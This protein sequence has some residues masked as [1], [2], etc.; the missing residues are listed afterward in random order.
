L[1]LR[2]GGGALTVHM[3]IA[4]TAGVG[5]T[6]LLGTALMLLVFLSAGTGHDDDAGAR[7]EDER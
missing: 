2:S 7:H 4:T 6:V 1:Y 3:I 5:L